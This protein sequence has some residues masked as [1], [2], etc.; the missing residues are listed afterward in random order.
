MLDRLRHCVARASNRMAG[1][2]IRLACMLDGITVKDWFTLGLQAITAGATITVAVYVARISRRQWWTNQEK[3]RLDLYNK[4]FEIYTR[5]L[6]FYQ[7]IVMW[8]ASAEQIQL[9]YPFLKA[10]RESR[11]LFPKDS[12]VFDYISEFQKHAFRIVQFDNLKPLAKI[13]PKEFLKH[14]KQRENSLSW[15]L[16]S[17]EGLEERLAPFLNFH[18][19]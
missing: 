3:L 17:M 4:R 19:I 15:L 10:F 13:D 6:D 11:F 9:Q 18:D 16:N 14:S 7:A 1:P 2:S 8:E 5:V 12:G